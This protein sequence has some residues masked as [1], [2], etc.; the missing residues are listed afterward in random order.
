MVAHPRPPKDRWHP[1]S[2]QQLTPCE[3]TSVVNAI[4]QGQFHLLP[5]TP[6]ESDDTSARPLDKQGRR[7]AAVRRHLHSRSAVEPASKKP[8]TDPAHTRT[9]SSARES[10]YV[11]VTP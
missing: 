8:L 10:W 6:E 4:L 5:L 1:C 9:V 7:A 3:L 2:L 11:S